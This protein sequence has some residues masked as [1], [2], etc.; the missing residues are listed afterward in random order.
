MFLIIL[1]LPRHRV[2]QRI[3]GRK[4]KPANNSG[5]P[6]EV[7]EHVARCLLPEILTDFEN[8]AVQIEFTKWKAENILGKKAASPSA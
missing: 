2:Q 6:N 1:G 5:F 7:I 3:L 4:K 8:E